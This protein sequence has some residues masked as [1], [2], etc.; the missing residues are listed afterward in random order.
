MNIAAKIGCEICAALFIKEKNIQDRLYSARCILGE[1]E[2]SRLRKEGGIKA[3]F[4][5]AQNYNE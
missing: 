1:D 5:A 2:Y 4:D 3:I